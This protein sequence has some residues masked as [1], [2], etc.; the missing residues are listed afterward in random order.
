MATLKELSKTSGVQG[1]AP[2]RTV[3]EQ[4]DAGMYASGELQYDDVAPADY[5]FTGQIQDGS[6]FH[7]CPTCEEDYCA[8][9]ST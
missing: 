6:K 5:G 1:I 2:G 8:S 3:G 9:C 4:R 7:H